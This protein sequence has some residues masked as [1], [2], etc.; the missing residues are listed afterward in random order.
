MVACANA[1]YQLEEFG[2]NKF[3]ET[4]YLSPHSYQD[5]PGKKTSRGQAPGRVAEWA[6]T[7]GSGQPLVDSIRW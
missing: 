3:L 2:E 5:A 4:C 6:A 1:I 7:A